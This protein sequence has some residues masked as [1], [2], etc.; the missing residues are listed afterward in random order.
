VAVADLLVVQVVAG[1]LGDGLFLKALAL[2]VQA[3]QRVLLLLVAILVMDTLLQAEVLVQTLL[4]T[5]LVVVVV[6]EVL[7]TQGLLA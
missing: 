2:L 3:A 1:F 7:A 6:A 4:I 5:V